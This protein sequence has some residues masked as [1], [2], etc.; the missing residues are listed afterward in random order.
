MIRS[1][2]YLKA[3]GYDFA[4]RARLGPQKIDHF[5]ALYSSVSSCTLCNFYKSRKH[6]L[7][8]RAEKSVKLLILDTHAQ[9]SENESGLLLNGS[10]GEILQRYLKDAL[11]IGRDEFY[12]SYVF[13]CFSG[14][15]HDDFSLQSCLPFFWNEIE[16][17]RPKILLCL[18][19]YAFRALGFSDFS[20]TRGGIFAHKNFFILASFSLEFLDKNPSQKKEFVSDLMKIKG[21]L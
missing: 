4:D 3:M 2:Y 12:L 8:E 14:G 13:K 10:K 5:K 15:N 19:E 7:M 21:Y 16:I 18:G 6:P 1:L 17:I 9:K 11:G 20:S